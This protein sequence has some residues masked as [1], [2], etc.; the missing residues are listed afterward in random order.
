MSLDQPNDLPSL[1]TTAAIGDIADVNPPGSLTIANDEDEVTF[2]PMAAVTELSGQVDLSDQRKFKDV[3]KGFTR[4]QDGDLLFAK[5]TPCMENGK[6]A[7]VRD[8]QGGVGC[9]STEFH[10]IRPASSIDVDYLRYFVVRSAFRQKAKRNMQGAVGQQ[11]VPPSFLREASIPIAPSNEQKRIVS[12]IDELFSHIEE[13]EQALQRVQKLVE[14]YRQ[15]VLKAAVTGELTREWREKHKGQLESGEALLTRILKARR[16]AWEKSELGKMN[17]KGQ[18]TKDDKWKNK[19]IEPAIPD[20]TYLP[21]L[22]KDWIWSSIGQLFSVS[23]GSTP[24]RKNPEYW[25]GDIPWVSSGEVA[26]CRI[27]ETRETITE[28]GFENSSVKLHPKGTVLLAMIG[29]GKTRGQAAILDIEA[30]H[31]QNAASIGVA[32]TPIPPEFVFYFLEFRYENVRNIGQGGNQPALNGD[33]VKNITIPL[34]PLLEI[35]QI[36]EII[37]KQFSA[38]EKISSDVKT[39]LAFIQSLRQTILREAFSGSLVP[40]D[41]KDEPASVLLER[42]NAEREKSAMKVIVKDRNKKKVKA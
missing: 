12:K 1:W 32:A 23:I 42:I 17:A 38:I 34:P 7:A 31:N 24:S 6:I 20:T 35:T 40:Q 29:E 30:C 25:G 5:I 11:R 37:E 28:L 41:P 8:L 9:G 4:F 39:Q 21:E 10:V 13:G 36:C 22:P 26:F 2:I 14:R 16:E 33:I 19:Y 27:R 18:R 3:K 15:S